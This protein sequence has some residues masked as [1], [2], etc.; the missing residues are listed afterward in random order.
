MVPIFGFARHTKTEPVPVVGQDSSL[1][2]L[3]PTV[4][5]SIKRKV[6]MGRTGKRRGQE[7]IKE[8]GAMRGGGGG[9][10]GDG[11][12]WPRRRPPLTASAM[13]SRHHIPRLVLPKRPTEEGWGARWLKRQKRAAEEGVMVA[14]YSSGWRQAVG[15]RWRDRSSQGKMGAGVDNGKQCRQVTEAL[16]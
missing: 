14:T 4:D 9:G 3:L 15:S 8:E 11:D 7:K 2:R 1:F 5:L 13:S 6:G 16:K 10:R 12:P